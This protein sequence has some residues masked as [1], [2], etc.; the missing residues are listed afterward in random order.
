MIATQLWRLP[1]FDEQGPLR[2]VGNGWVLRHGLAALNTLVP[3][4]IAQLFRKRVPAL[5]RLDRCLGGSLDGLGA[6]IGSGFDQSEL[7]GG[8]CLG[9]LECGN[10]F[11]MRNGWVHS[12]SFIDQRHHTEIWTLARSKAVLNSRVDG[13]DRSTFCTARSNEEP[14]L[15]QAGTIFLAGS[16]AG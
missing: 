6:F 8:I 3:P 12:G 2:A 10:Q 14:G 16:L 9:P 5:C 11:C 13:F 4:Q 7:V 1:V 15:I